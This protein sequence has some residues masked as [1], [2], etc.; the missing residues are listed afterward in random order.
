MWWYVWLFN[1]HWNTKLS[2]DSVE[3][4][5]IHHSYTVGHASNITH[6]KHA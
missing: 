3:Y 1:L 5:H 6:I 4:L 2:L